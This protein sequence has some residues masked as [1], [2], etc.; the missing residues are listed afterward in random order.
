LIHSGHPL[1]KPLELADLNYVNEKAALAFLTLAMNPADYTMVF[2]G[3]LG[4]REEFRKLTEMYLAS[5]PNSGLPRWNSWIDPEIKRPEKTEKTIRKGKEEKCIVY[6][7]WYIPKVWT[8]EI[9]ASVLAL[10]EYLD[11]VLTDEIREKLGGVY[12]ISPYASISPAPTGELS[13]E[14]Y[15]ICD[16]GRAEELRRAV[17]KQ[18]VSLCS[19]TDEET[20]G[21]AKE[22]LVKNFEQSIENNGFLARNLANFSVITETPLSHLPERPAL[23]RAVTGESIRLL[24]AEL[25]RGGPIELVLMPESAD[26]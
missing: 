14:L 16:P 6:M 2:A 13:L 17:D 7:G 20:V 18:L 19:A 10:N 23:Y 15:F 5:I 11:I 21:R 25:L 12:S 24:M 9:N 1:F 22:A 26:K 3:S 8:E 4:D